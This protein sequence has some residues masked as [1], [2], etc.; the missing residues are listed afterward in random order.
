MFNCMKVPI[1][2]SFTRQIRNFQSRLLFFPIPHH[3][4]INRLRT[5][6][7]MLILLTNTVVPV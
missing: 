1:G 3:A 2:T 4:D 6:T 5:A 7:A